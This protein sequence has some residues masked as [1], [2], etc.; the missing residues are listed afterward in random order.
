MF[1]FVR[2]GILSKKTFQPKINSKKNHCNDN[3]RRVFLQDVVFFLVSQVISSLFSF[4]VI[5]EILTG[6]H[7]T[8]FC[9]IHLMPLFRFFVHQRHVV[10]HKIHA[11]R[12][13]MRALTDWLYGT[14]Q[15]FQF[16]VRQFTCKLKNWRWNEKS[17][18]KN[19]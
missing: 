14:S 7:G 3:Y 18:F 6:F 17:L 19:V 12:Q 8:N 13:R 9:S 1:G 2:K 5:F 16:I 4:I 10:V 15:F 11:F